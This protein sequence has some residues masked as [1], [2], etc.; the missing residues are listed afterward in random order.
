[1]ESTEDPSF[2]DKRARNDFPMSKAVLP[3]AELSRAAAG[4]GAAAA[5]AAAAAAATPSDGPEAM[6]QDDGVSDVDVDGHSDAADDVSD[7][8]DDGRMECTP[9]QGL[10]V[11]PEVDAAAAAAAMASL[12]GMSTETM[13]RRQASSVT[14]VMDWLVRTPSVTGLK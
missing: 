5:S 8:S 10:P 11:P 1:M 12:E 7:D 4:A 6:D 2:G 14:K 9:P 3:G 13:T